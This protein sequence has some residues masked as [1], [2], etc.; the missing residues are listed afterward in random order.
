[1]VTLIAASAAAYTVTQNNKGLPAAGT[2]AA[3]P[4][5]LTPVRLRA[6]TPARPRALTPARPAG[7]HEDEV[8]LTPE[9]AA[10][11]G[12][13]VEAARKQPLGEV[14]TVPARISYNTEGM[15]HVGTPVGGRVAEIK[16]KLGDMVK[17][18]DELL[19]IDSPALGEAQSDYLQKKTQAQVAQS[20]LG[21]AQT[22]AE[23]AR[24]LYEGQGDR[25]GR[26]SEARGGFQGRERCAQVGRR[27]R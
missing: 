17:K 25:A 8:T 26:V 24:R 20:A 16:V 4:R 6:L 11:N 22:G 14:Y 2:N 27:R 9:A 18:G 5:A 7:A 21:V 10:Q 1:M 15:A 3:P 13:K 23:R 19:A 12:I